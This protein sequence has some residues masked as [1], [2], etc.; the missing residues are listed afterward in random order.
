MAIESVLAQTYDPSRLEVIVVDD[1]ST[2]DT[3]QVIC[4]YRESHPGIVRDARTPGQSGTPALPRNLGL[5]MAR[6][7]YVFFLDSD[8]WLG[9][10]A[11]RRM[12]AHAADWDCD[13]LVVKLKGEGGREAPRS[14]ART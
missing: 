9:E 14:G 11:A 6:G 7:E 5:Q 10:D 12:L 3:P 4:A 8:D 13:V 1:C 2:D